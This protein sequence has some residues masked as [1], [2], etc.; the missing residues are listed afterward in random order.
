MEKERAI[1]LM[2]AVPLKHGAPGGFETAALE[3]TEEEKIQILERKLKELEE[4]LAEKGKIK[5]EKPE[6][7]EEGTEEK[8]QEGEEGKKPPE[9]PE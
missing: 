8:G 3:P 4:K 1:G 2:P 7:K 6:E 5:E 9:K